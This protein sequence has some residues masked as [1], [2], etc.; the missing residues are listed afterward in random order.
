M[1]VLASA[2][3]IVSMS[4]MPACAA[5]Q[6][7]G[8]ADARPA[9]PREPVPVRDLLAAR[10]F[11]VA[12]PYR[13]TWSEERAM[14]TRGTLIVVEVDP[15]LA[16]RRDTF[17]P[18]LFAGDTIVIRLNDGDQSGRIVGIVPGDVDLATAPIW[19]GPSDL[20]ERMSAADVRAELARAAKAG[21]RAFP[22][23]KLADVT[24]PAV[25]AP[26]LGALLRDVAAQLVY[27]FAP[28]DKEIADSWR[29]PEAK[30][31]VRPN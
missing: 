21:V 24:R 11:T 9:L 16:V 18:V 1:K 25:T 2:V 8:R 27:E 31:P 19:I 23:T 30:N 20:P 26:D 15:A 14:V 13:N 7:Q 17:E 4:V 29:L 5:M 3:L 6:T 28:E 22:R 12:T 10:P